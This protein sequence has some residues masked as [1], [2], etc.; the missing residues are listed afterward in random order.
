MGGSRLTRQL[1]FILEVEKVKQ[2]FRQTVLL[3]DN[4]AENDAEHSWH[5]SLMALVLAEHA[6]GPGLD[7]LR[8]LHMLLIHDLVEIDAGDTFAYDEAGNA[9]KLARETA[10]AERIFALLPADQCR[11]I[12]GLWEEFEARRT[13]E[14]RYAAA[15]DRLQPILLN[16]HSGG[17]AWKRHGISRRQVV[18]RNRTMAEG[19]PA[20]WRYALELIDAAVERGYLLP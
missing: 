15:L 19:A 14:A 8:V 17:V 20:L 10:A 18:E 5:L 3:H 7:M 6:A 1:E 9:D 2:V 16:Y 4:R 12:R 13:P 11:H